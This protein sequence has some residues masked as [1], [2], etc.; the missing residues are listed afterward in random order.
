M[1]IN[2][3]HALISLFPRDG[4]IKNGGSVR[5]NKLLWALGN[6]SFFVRPGYK[7]VALEG[8]DD[9][10]TLAASAYIAPDKSRMVVVLVNSDF[11]T[12]TVKINFPEAFSKKINAVSLF[13][14]DQQTDLANMHIDS[15]YTAGRPFIIASRSVTTMVFRLK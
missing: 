10:N 7:R 9:L 3:D 14:T 8:A 12:P 4:N 13:R 6:Y 5:S 11:D 1:E 15:Q 2:G